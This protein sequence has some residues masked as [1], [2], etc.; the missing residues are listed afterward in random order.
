MKRE[1]LKNAAV[2]FAI[3]IGALL[4]SIAGGWLWYV[5]NDVSISD[6]F[7]VFCWKMVAMMFGVIIAIVGGAVFLLG[8]TRVFKNLGEALFTKENI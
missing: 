7:L 5:A 1:A 6:Q 8:V 3:A 4:L 2:N